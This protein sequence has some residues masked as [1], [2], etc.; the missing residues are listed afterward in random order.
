MHIRSFVLQACRGQS[1]ITSHVQ[2]VFQHFLDGVMLTPTPAHPDG[3]RI[4]LESLVLLQE[5]GD[6]A[7]RRLLSLL[8]MLHMTRA[9]PLLRSLSKEHLITLAAAATAA[10][11]A[12]PLPS[13]AASAAAPGA[14]WPPPPRPLAAA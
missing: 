8:L 14:A 3:I 7:A 10:P 11:S 9:V 13:A 1:D 6:A 5:H 2:V 4:Q 12:P